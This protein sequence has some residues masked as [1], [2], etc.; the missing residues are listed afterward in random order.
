MTEQEYS[1]FIAGLNELSRNLKP[2][3]RIAVDIVDI[4]TG[5]IVDDGSIPIL[6]IK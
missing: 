5:E 2:N 3:E 4:K 1:S 6:A